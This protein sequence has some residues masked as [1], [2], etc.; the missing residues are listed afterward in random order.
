MDIF[1]ASDKNFGS[2]K[3][4]KGNYIC[5]AAG[6][7][8]PVESRWRNEKKRTSWMTQASKNSKKYFWELKWDLN[9]TSWKFQNLMLNTEIWGYVL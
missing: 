2:E 4:L 3:I 8:A 7:A 5:T 6:A 9:M 1:N